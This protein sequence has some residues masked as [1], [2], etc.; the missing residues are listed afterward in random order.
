M[1]FLLTGSSGFIGTRLLNAINDNLV[2]LS[3][4]NNTSFPTIICDFEKDEI[5]PDTFLSIDVVI[6]LAAIAHNTTSKTMGVNCLITK[7]ITDVFINKKVKFIFF[8]SIA[9]YG[10]ANRQFPIKTSGFCKPYSSYGIGKF[11][12]D[13][14]PIICFST[15][16]TEHSL[17]IPIFCCPF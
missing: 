16:H 4:N 2:L 17:A 9:V 6:H 13:I 11:C 5:P 3:R 10:E 8:S 1:K 12:N 15:H 7:N 14:S